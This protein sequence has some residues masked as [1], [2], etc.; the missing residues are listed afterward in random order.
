MKSNCDAC[1]KYLTYNERNLAKDIEYE[2]NIYTLCRDCA[3]R[4]DDPE[5][6]KQVMLNVTQQEEVAAMEEQKEQV[7]K[8]RHENM[9]LTT[10]SSIEG[11]PVQEYKGIVGA[12]V[13]AGIGPFKDTFAAIRNVVG[14]RSKSLQNSMRK[15]REQVLQELKEE[16]Y[17]K[18]A[19]AVIAVKID[20]DEYSEGMMMLTATG[21]A[22]IV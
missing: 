17:T 11:K 13:M 15:M 22:V 5:V 4:A 9:I 1:G 12:Q 21:T 7:D 3:P 14:G 10:S 18:G 19:S 2:G 8:E 20:F 6:I 16:A